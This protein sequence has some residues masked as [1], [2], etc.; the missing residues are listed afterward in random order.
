MTADD[1][2]IARF[3]LLGRLLRESPVAG[4][5]GF[6]VTMRDRDPLG[7]PDSVLPKLDG[8]DFDEMWLFAVDVGDGLNRRGL[9]RHLAFSPQWSRADG[10]PRS[11]GLGLLCTD[12]G[13]CR[14][15]SSFSFAQSGSGFHPARGRRRRYGG[16]FLPNYHSGAN[17]D[18]QRIS[19]ADPGATPCWPIPNLLPGSSGI[20]LPIPTR[21]E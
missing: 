16:N 1:W 10:H 7:A 17:G 5:R 20:C 21:V 19:V 4:G 12:L 13:W 6:E 18:F 15:G 2:S 8:S 14:P 3:G 9:R 11:H